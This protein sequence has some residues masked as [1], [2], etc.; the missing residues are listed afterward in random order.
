M[1]SNPT[2]ERSGLRRRIRL[3]PAPGRISAGLE[4]DYHHFE[5]RLSHADGVITAADA[6]AVRFPWSTCGGASEL[7]VRQSV[8]KRLQAIAALDAHAHCTH[9]FELAVLAA[10][11]A[12]DTSPTQFDMFV[13]DRVDTRT[14]A[15]LSRDGAPLL[16]WDLTGLSIDAPSDW[17]GRDLRKLSVWRAQLSPEQAEQAGLLRRAVHISGGR[18]L[19][20][21]QMPQRAG[22][23]GGGSRTGAC[24]THQAEC[25]AIAVRTDGWRRDFSTT[26]ED[27]LR[28]FR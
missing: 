16:R 26:P 11:H 18:N 21:D 22:D 15:T 17:A 25:A 5:V 6:E 1:S 23:V 4:D 8:G 12:R 13:A 3:I 9:L 27:L 7:L 2:T 14:Y 19:T 20:L 28:D 10:A 24:F